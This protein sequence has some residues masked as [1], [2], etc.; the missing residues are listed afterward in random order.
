M[1]KSARERRQGI[2][3]DKPELTELTTK[4]AR[5][6]DKESAATNLSWPSCLAARAD[7]VGG[8]V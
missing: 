1:T 2:S 5:S 6:A 4:S 7:F 3:R 8:S